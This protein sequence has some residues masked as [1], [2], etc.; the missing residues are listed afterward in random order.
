MIGQTISHYRIVSKLGGGG[1]GVVY[2]AEDTRLD[3][4]VALKFLPEDLAR[5]H[6]A[7][8]R[9][10]RE[11]KAAS[12]LN[13]PNICTIYDIGEQ[14]GRAFIAME[15][16]DGNTLKHAIASHPME[17]DTLLS[18][19]IEIADALDAAHAKNIV[20]RDIKPANIFVTDRGHAKILDFGLAKV[21]SGASSSAGV[22]QATVESDHLTSPGT[23]V[24]TVAYMSPEQARGKELDARTD[25]FSFG[26][27]LYE[28]A[29]G[30]LP[31]RGDSSADL[32]DSILHKI[33]AAPVRLNPDVPA[34]LEDIINKALE[35]DRE[36][37]YQHAS[38][39][40]AD[41]KRLKRETESGRVPQRSDETPTIAGTTSASG[42]SSTAAPS[43]PAIAAGQS[44]I[45]QRNASQPA[46]SS[47]RVTTSSS[48]VLI[49]EAGRHKSVVF[50]AA[51]VVI[52]L[53]AAA[54]FGIY[55]FF[56]HN[57]PTID[58]RNVNI[59][60]LTEHG[61]SVGI[62]TISS[63]GRLVAYVRREGERSLRV[64]QVTTGSEVT[65]VPPQTGFFGTGATFTPDGNYLYYTHGDPAN[66]NNIN[67]YAVP[68]L[69]GAS[70]QIASDVASTVAF[71][72][73]GKRMV[74]RRTIK[75]KTDYQLL[76]ANSDGS[77]EKV[78]FRRPET[79]KQFY[80]D[81]SWSVSGDLIAVGALELGQNVISSILVLTP[82]GKL[83]KTFPFPILVAQVAWLPDGSG[84]FFIGGE[85][86]T[87]L[88]PQIWFQP[89]PTGEPFKITNDLSRYG[90]LGVTADGKSF[91]TTQGRP[92]ATIYVSDSPTVL[93][94]KVERKLT[95]ISNEQATGYSLSWTATGKLIQTDSAAH[96]YVTGADG[97]NRVRLL[98]NDYWTDEPA[99]C[100]PDETVIVPIMKEDNAMHLWRLNSATGE[101][102]Q[103][104]SGKWESG[105]SCTPDG[106]WVLYSGIAADGL[107]HV[108]KIPIDGGTPVE[109]ASRTDARPVASPDGTEILYGK[110]DGQGASA[111]SKF[112]VQKL[113]GG[114]LVQEIDAPSTY[115]RS[116]L[117]W[118]PDGHALTFINNTTGNT[119]NV[120]MQ[121]LAGG[122]P[123][124]L[125]HF[126]S[127][128]AVVS[129]YA[130]SRD[131]K[132]FAVT[133]SRYNDTDVVMFS[134]F[135]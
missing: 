101:V 16:L 6:Q 12:A 34:K 41:L 63:D 132:K 7:L 123:V 134:G 105:A 54:G 1:M 74:Y 81:P 55:K 77:N 115:N 23:A 82:E 42:V 13:H 15:F 53:L 128:P 124:Q 17:L 102:K 73:D 131:G 14:D 130:W 32:F 24:G 85:K 94:D 88:R 11:A 120:Y 107:D 68:S 56:G 110:T 2:K 111:K 45:S 114:A 72:P 76:V 27:V 70:R 57:G 9:F 112:V 61:Q 118:T 59:R 36:L 90:S 96:G 43:A 100:G 22:T 103:L 125:T 113:E 127:E 37:R 135:R 83:V 48:S 49:A 66:A 129:A 26:A 86:S 106:K 51:A 65:V 89:Y 40:R 97:S 21:T 95:P 71:S 20:H 60:P 46:S 119:M 39:M 35:K 109:M 78:I 5:D 3:R 93:N 117:G 8:E 28:M 98:E 52:L 116:R 92:Q 4:F 19:A 84:I 121:P 126:D 30:T 99:A 25:L 29:T 80:T 69:G 104:T 44:S 108:Y 31:F 75:D 87:G 64:K 47:A 79:V 133:R 67:L 18:L 10:R 50:A 38:E 91:V 62:A 58:T 33:P 122:A